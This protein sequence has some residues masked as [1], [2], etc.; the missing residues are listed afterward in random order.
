F[1]LN[2][3]KLGAADF[4]G[5]VNNNK[6]NTN[7]K[8][9][10]NVFVDN[11]KKFLSKFGIYKKKK[12]HPSL[13]ISGNF[14]LDSSKMTFYEIENNEKLSNED[15]SYIE[16]E[17]NNLMFENDYESL[18]DFSKFKEFIKSIQIENN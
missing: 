1:L 2:L 9:E 10:S 18:F 7:F 12:I 6:K 11:E 15:V 4:L 3:G 13:F 8:F 16:N 14:D 5:S 17:F